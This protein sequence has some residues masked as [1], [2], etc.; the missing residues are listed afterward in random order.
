MLRIGAASSLIT[1]MVAPGKVEFQYA[2]LSTVANQ[3]PYSSSQNIQQ[4]CI[5]NYLGSC[6]CGRQR[7][8]VLDSGF[9]SRAEPTSKIFSLLV[10]RRKIHIA[11]QG[12]PRRRQSGRIAQLV[13]QLTLNQRVPGSSPGAPT[14]QFN[15]LA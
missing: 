5:R 6:R 4:F 7:Y 2:E 3:P 12:A 8:L 1:P 13:E 10:I 15:N 9:I 14:I 11:Q